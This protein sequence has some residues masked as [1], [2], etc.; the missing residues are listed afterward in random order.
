MNLHYHY[1]IVGGGI[2]ADAAVRGIR[3]VDSEG[4]IG[5]VSADID[6]PYTRPWLSKGLW[7]GESPDRVWLKT[8]DRGV[9]M[10]LGRTI[11]HFDLGE[12]RLT[13][14][15][16]DT[17]TFDK[18]L[19]ATGVRPRQLAPA[20]DRIFPFRSLADYWKLSALAQAG[21]R[22]A[23]IGSGFIGSEIAAALAMSGKD[24]ELIFPEAAIG[25]RLFPA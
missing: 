10:H 4:P 22:F 20:S 9:E 12:N 18:L 24:V 3:D 21:Q 1:L 8:A 7:K 2:A 16:G 17:F 6:P 19:M 15:R 5:L 14:E 11:E 25:D 13:D 23:V